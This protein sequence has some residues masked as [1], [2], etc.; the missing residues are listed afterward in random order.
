VKSDRKLGGLRWWK[1]IAGLLALAL[2]LAFSFSALGWPGMA[3]LLVLVVLAVSVRHRLPRVTAAIETL[4]GLVLLIIVYVNILGWVVSGGFLRAWMA[5]SIY[6]VG[7]ILF[8]AWLGL[9]IGR[10]LRKRS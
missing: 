9:I 8:V 5:I 2:L 10:R 1:A 3:T 4:G 7:G 6:T